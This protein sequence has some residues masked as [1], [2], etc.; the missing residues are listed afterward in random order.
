[1]KD[2]SRKYRKLRSIKL[3]HKNDKTF[4]FI[5][6]QFLYGRRNTEKYE[7]NEQLFTEVEVNRPGYSQVNILGFSPTLR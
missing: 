2:F 6:A 7:N 3:Q 4:R 1:M 5:V